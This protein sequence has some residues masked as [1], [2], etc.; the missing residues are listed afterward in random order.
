MS[1]AKNKKRPTGKVIA[2]IVVALL[3]VAVLAALGLSIASNVVLHNKIADYKSTEPPF[4]SGNVIVTPEDPAP[5]IALLSIDS[6]ELLVAEEKTA[7]FSLTVTPDVNANV[8][9]RWSIDFTNPDSEW[10][11][12]K[13]VTEY[14]TIIRAG[15]F[16]ATVS[17][18]KA[19]GE[20]ITVKAAVKNYEEVYVT[21]TVDYAC[22]YEVQGFNIEKVENENNEGSAKITPII[23]KS[24]GTVDEEITQTITLGMNENYKNFFVA[25]AATARIYTLGLSE[26][27]QAKYLDNYFDNFKET[28]TEELVTNLYGYIGENVWTLPQK[29]FGFVDLESD[30]YKVHMER[31]FG[32]FLPKCIPANPDFK[33]IMQSVKRYKYS[34][35]YISADEAIEVNSRL[36]TN[37]LNNAKSNTY[38][39]SEVRI[40]TAHSGLYSI[41]DAFYVECQLTNAYNNV[42]YKEDFAFIFKEMP[43]VGSLTIDPPSIIL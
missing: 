39:F 18:K 15:N 16:T 13:A 25:N 19:F 23:A 34:Y 26:S 36:N 7:D 35:G 28:G 6:S 20:Q 30:R 41:S 32:Y 12:G 2:K 38:G 8:D 9:I 3:S 43:V 17:V 5:G 42:T 37:L 14:A 1:K 22:K 29:A 24:I 33:D 4:D 21:C 31:F 27:A 11:Q 40:S 10:A